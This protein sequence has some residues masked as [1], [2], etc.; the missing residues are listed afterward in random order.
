[1]VK[2][3]SKMW[4]EIALEGRWLTI[5]NLLTVL[6]ILLIPIII[7]GIANHLW[8][9]VFFL[10]LFAGVT[11]V[12]DG[13]LARWLDEQ[14]V[15]GACLD[16]IADKLLLIA[17]FATLSFVDS[18]SFSIP[19]WFVF[20]VCAREAIILG[21]SFFLVF[22]GIHLR[23]APSIWGKMTTFFQLLFILW[24][25]VCYFVGWNPI[26]TYSILLVLLAVFSL[27]SLGQYAVVGMR[28]LRG[29]P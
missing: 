20:F 7:F 11:D 24:I 27:F 1:M 2:K 17:S 25:F 8:T 23:I 22:R 4:K 18:P 5:S 6:R 19:S 29:K 26:K 15:L 9:F 12:L 10:F 28:Y 14:T 16:P 3:I 21:G 13:Q